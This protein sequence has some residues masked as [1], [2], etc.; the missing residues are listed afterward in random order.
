MPRIWRWKNHPDPSAAYNVE[1]ETEYSA[2]EKIAKE[3]N[4][5]TEVIQVER[6]YLLPRLTIGPVEA[7]EDSVG[8]VVNAINN[9]AEKVENVIYAL[10]EDDQWAKR[11]LQRLEN[12]IGKAMEPEDSYG[13]GLVE[14][15]RQLRTWMEETKKSS[16]QRSHTARRQD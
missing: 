10:E 2:R 11:Q 12:T 7:M 3:H 5:R 8:P 6:V 9:L 14:D 15:V 4:L 1:A 13:Y 16:A